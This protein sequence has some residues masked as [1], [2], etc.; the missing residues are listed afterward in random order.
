[1]YASKSSSGVFP[2]SSDAKRSAQNASRVLFVFF[3]GD[4]A[5]LLIAPNVDLVALEAE[6]GGQADGLAAA[7]PEQF[8]DR[9]V[10]HGVLHSE[11][12]DTSM[13]LKQ[14]SIADWNSHQHQ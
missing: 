3:E 7:V 4:V 14:V 2:A 9:D 13:Y 11:C 8:G 10:A 5:G 1:M 12:L 6:L